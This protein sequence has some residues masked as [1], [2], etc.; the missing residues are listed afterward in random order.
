MNT[1]NNH[2]RLDLVQH[3]GVNEVPVA[4][5]EITLPVADLYFG[6]EDKAVEKEIEPDSEFRAEIKFLDLYKVFR[7]LGAGIARHIDIGLVAGE[8]VD[9]EIPDPVALEFHLQRKGHDDRLHFFHDLGLVVDIGEFEFVK[10]ISF[11][12]HKLRV[13]PELEA[14]RYPGRGKQTKGKTTR[15]IGFGHIDTVVLQES[16]IEVRMK[17]CQVYAHGQTKIIRFGIMVGLVL[18]H[19]GILRP[20]RIGKKAGTGQQNQGYQEDQRAFCPV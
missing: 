17:T 13:E 19:I 18:L 8:G 6:G 5:M 1:E 20:G 7:L 4:G 2:P 10:D 14:V 11:Q 15:V 16:G 3:I 12:K 9:P